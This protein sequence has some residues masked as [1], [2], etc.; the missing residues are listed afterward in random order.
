MNTSGGIVW[1]GYN[2]TFF[3]NKKYILLK[4]DILK[5]LISGVCWLWSVWLYIKLLSTHTYTHIPSFLNF[6]SHHFHQAT[7]SSHHNPLVSQVALHLPKG[8]ARP[9][10][11][12]AGHKLR[13]P[14]AGSSP[15]ASASYGLQRSGLDRNIIR[16]LDEIC[17]IIPRWLQWSWNVSIFVS[18]ALAGP[19][20]TQQ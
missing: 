1:N 13:P 15:T 19:V 9:Q 20:G 3:P 14:N 7:A 8:P 18:S 17:K 2:Q 10:P 4:R 16:T 6:L 5:L 12:S 11:L